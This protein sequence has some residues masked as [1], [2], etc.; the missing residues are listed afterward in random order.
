VADAAST[1][2]MRRAGEL[3]RILAK[4]LLDGSD[5]GR[6]TEARSCPALRRLGKMWTAPSSGE[7]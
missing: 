1:T 4:H 3:L 6:Q 2:I 7:R 5:P